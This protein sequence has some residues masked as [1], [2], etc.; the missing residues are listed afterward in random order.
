MEGDQQLRPPGRNQPSV[1]KRRSCDTA[2]AQLEHGLRID[3]GC[4]RGLYAGPL[5]AQAAPTTRHHGGASEPRACSSR[6]CRCEAWDRC[7][8]GYT[9]ERMRSRVGD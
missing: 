4:A 8:R 5:S 6:V 1:R 2:E 7:E 3:S 9:V